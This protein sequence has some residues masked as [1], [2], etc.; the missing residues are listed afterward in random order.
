MATTITDLRLANDLSCESALKV[1]APAIKY[2]MLTE[3]QQKVLKE[4]QKNQGNTAKV[5]VDTR[6]RPHP[7]S[8]GQQRG[9]KNAHAFL[10]RLLRLQLPPSRQ[11]A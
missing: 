5:E 9:W 7:Y 11:L 6:N 1:S 10:C 4:L 3:E 2:D 8:G